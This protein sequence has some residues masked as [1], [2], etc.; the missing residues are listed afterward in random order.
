MN[1]YK[2]INVMLKNISVLMLGLT[3]ASTAAMAS[4][5]TPEQ[6]LAR[7]QSDSGARARVKSSYQMSLAY[8]AEL[9]VGVPVAYVFVN[10][11][12]DGFAVL[13]ADDKAL[14]LL[15]YSETGSFDADNLPPSFVWWMS[16][17]GR[18]IESVDESDVN[19]ES[20]AVY[21]PHNWEAIS[22]LMTTKWN[23]DVPFNL[24]TPMIDGVQ[25]PTG[26]VATSVAQVMNYFKYPDIGA[27]FIRYSNKGKTFTLNLE[28]TPFDWDNMLDIY[29]PN[30]YTD[31][32]ADAVAY[33]MKA[34]GYSVEMAYGEVASGAQ[35]Y[36]I[37][38][39]AIN[40]FKYDPSIKYVD[41]NYYSYDQ[42][43][44]M[45]YENIKNV[46]PVI[47]NGTS[48]GGGHS[49]VCDGYD[50]KGYFHFNW[51]WGG[52]SDGYYVLDSLN[53][54]AQ[55]IGGSTAASGGF[56]YSQDV[57]LGMQKPTGKPAEIDYATLNVYGSLTA[58][59]RGNDITFS[60]INSSVAGWG[61]PTYRQVKVKVGAIITGV[62]GTTYESVSEG[63][64]SDN[65]A[66]VS[67]GLGTYYPAETYYPIVPIPSGL[68]DG[69]YKVTLAAQDLDYTDAPWKP[70][71]AYYG[72][73]NYC[74]LEIKNGK[75]TVTSVSPGLLN[76]SEVEF[77][78]PVYYGR[79]A[80]LEA[81]INNESDYQLTEC[82]FPALY[83]DGKARFQGD[84]MLITVDPG[85]T[86]Q[87]QWLVSLQDLSNSS[88]TSGEYTLCL[89]NQDT[90]VVIGEYGKYKIEFTSTGLKLRLE[91][92]AVD[93][94]EQKDVVVGSR[95]FKDVYIVDN[96][97]D[98]DLLF[99]YQVREGY[100]DT[101][102]RILYGEYMPDV[103]KFDVSEEDLYYDTPFLGT[104][105]KSSVTIPLDFSSKNQYTVYQ[106]RASYM[107]G[108]SSKTLGLSYV[109]FKT[110]GVDEI[111]CDA[112]E[113]VEYYNMQGV[114]IDSPRHGEI[115][116][117]KTSDKTE[118]VRF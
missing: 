52:M 20:S 61:N 66:S 74:Y 30:S 73:A 90:G 92:L 88:D 17:Y 58:S 93:G 21:A 24:K 26:C 109:G 96:P 49:F 68:G 41:R 104:G 31:E 6:A 99:S 14:P 106:L 48:M 64:M 3:I 65:S 39:A 9:K 108:G 83:K 5:L 32:Q 115:V 27:G 43:C 53:P 100:F 2:L 101:S 102:V 98:F 110:S 118:K 87:H 19:R 97:S 117:K 76:F 84:V 16:E 116:I 72:M 54:E 82:F 25:S 40:N 28:K 86:V 1:F 13:S 47:Y 8:T 51:G 22:P 89:V 91:E 56:N 44:T 57:V 113:S 33:L 38:N 114:R 62:D 81:T 18:R 94:A 55:G 15:G 34:C 10:Q 37:I 4:P 50:G 78:S 36:K 46:G 67:M 75:A 23:Q 95:T 105:E 35:S 112:E 7:L 80:L 69:K 42:W 77:G 59:L 71:L 70:F 79:N 111:S 12:A 11:D 29:E 63:K 103:N 60:A 45:I 107:Y 85:E